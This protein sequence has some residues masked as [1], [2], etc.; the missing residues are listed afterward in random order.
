M[1]LRNV[2][3]EV[4]EP[5]GIE[6][7]EEEDEEDLEDK[8]SAI[9]Q[10]DILPPTAIQMPSTSTAASGMETRKRQTTARMSVPSRNQEPQSQENGRSRG[11]RKAREVKCRRCYA[12]VMDTDIA[13]LNHVNSE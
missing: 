3:E 11:K 9:M 12:N 6:N 13:K 8:E 2:K 1:V 4:V 10:D 7:E 5:H